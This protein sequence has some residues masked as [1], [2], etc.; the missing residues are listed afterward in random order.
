MGFDHIQNHHA[1][2]DL[3]VDVMHQDSTMMATT[4]QNVFD[5]SEITGQF[6]I[7]LLEKT[8]GIFIHSPC[9]LYIWPN[10]IIFHQRRLS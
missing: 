10:G 3:Y 1:W 6:P 2:E 8:L 9:F 7:K 4:C 5:R